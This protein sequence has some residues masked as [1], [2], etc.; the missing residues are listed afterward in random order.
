MQIFELLGIFDTRS[1]TNIQVSAVQE[2]VQQTEKEL[3]VIKYH[4]N[5]KRLNVASFPYKDD[6]FC[7]FFAA[8]VCGAKEEGVLS[9]LYSSGFVVLNVLLKDTFLE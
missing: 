6:G 9:S 5:K 3:E 4:S 8:I 1:S 2:K 7:C